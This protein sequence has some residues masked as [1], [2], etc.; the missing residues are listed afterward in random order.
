[1]NNKQEEVNCLWLLFSVTNLQPSYLSQMY[2]LYHEEP[3]L[4]SPASR[5]SC[6]LSC[7]SAAGEADD[8]WPRAGVSED[9]VQVERRGAGGGGYV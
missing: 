7:L 3:L 1:M 9:N 5:P 2:Y 8:N 4:P 6:D